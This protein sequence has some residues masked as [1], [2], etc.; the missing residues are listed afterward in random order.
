MHT[1]AATIKGKMA[2]HN[3]NN[4]PRLITMQI[5]T[6]AYAY[7]YAYA[8]SSQPQELQFLHSLGRGDAYACVCL[9]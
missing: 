4:A 5:Y 8:Y 2:E 6:Y 1:F 3:N 9:S 7:A